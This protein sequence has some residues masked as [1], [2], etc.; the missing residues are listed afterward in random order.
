MHAHPGDQI[1]IRGHHVGDLDRR[2]EILE[3][4][5]ADGGPP[6][7]VRWD[8]KEHEV[9]FFPGNDATIDSLATHGGQDR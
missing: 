9:L 4:R 7:L 1:R 6:F 5:G 8:D 3:T 2:G